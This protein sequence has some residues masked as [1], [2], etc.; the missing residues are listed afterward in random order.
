[1]ITLSHPVEV[2]GKRIAMTRDADGSEGAPER[3]LD[4]V[5]IG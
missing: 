3:E 4:G 5:G 1:M 2:N